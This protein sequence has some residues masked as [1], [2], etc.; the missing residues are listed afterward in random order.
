MNEKPRA[1]RD[2]EYEISMIAKKD[3]FPNAGKPWDSKEQLDAVINRALRGQDYG[4]IDADLKLKR[5]GYSL[6]RQVDWLWRNE[7]KRA[8]FNYEPTEVRKWRGE[9]PL[10]KREKLIIRYHRR[11]SIPPKVTGRFLRRKASYVEALS[12][13]DIAKEPPSTEE[14]RPATDEDGLRYTKIKKKSKVGVGSLIDSISTVDIILAHRYLYYC[15]K[16]PVI[17]DEA[18][19]TFKHEEAEF[20]GDSKELAAKVGDKPLDFPDHIRS[21][22]YYMLYKHEVKKDKPWTACLP[23]GWFKPK[24]K[25]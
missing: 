2:H 17:S 16:H 9:K 24:V 18:Y 12:E 5:G 10:T 19:D 14:P 6:K 4:R 3:L 21:L 11:K 15:S 13:A 25:P 8:L 1:K 23:Y 20:G 22:G 7:N